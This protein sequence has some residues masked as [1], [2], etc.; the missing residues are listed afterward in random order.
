MLNN[1]TVGVTRVT[2]KQLGLRWDRLPGRVD[3]YGRDYYF[4]YNLYGWTGPFE[5]AVYLSE[6][7][8]LLFVTVKEPT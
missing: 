2:V 3:Y 7:D 8:A 6:P 5:G 1:T 4:W